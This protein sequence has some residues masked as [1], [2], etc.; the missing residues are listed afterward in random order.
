VFSLAAVKLLASLVRYIH[1]EMCIQNECDIFASQMRYC[2]G[3]E[4]SEI[5]AKRNMFRFAN[6]V[7]STLPINPHA[8]QFAAYRLP[9]GKYR[10]LAACQSISQIR[11]DLYRFS[12]SCV[13]DKLNFQP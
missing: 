7:E 9:Q 11:E 1:F 8:A 13:Q 12:L 6:V 3:I 10:G 5:F 2:S 4:N